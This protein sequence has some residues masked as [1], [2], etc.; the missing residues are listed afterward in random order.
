MSGTIQQHQDYLQANT[1]LTNLL[2]MKGCRNLYSTLAER[3]AAIPTKTSHLV[4]CNSEQGLQTLLNEEFNQ[5][6]GMVKTEELA[7]GII[8]KFLRVSSQDIRENRILADTDLSRNVAEIQKIKGFMEGH[9][10]STS[11]CLL[12]M[13]GKTSYWASYFPDVNH[14]YFKQAFE[15]YKKEQEAREAARVLASAA[16]MP[17]T[18]EGSPVATKSQDTTTAAPTSDSAALMPATSEGSPVTTKSQDITTAA[19]TSE[20]S[21]VATTSADTPTV[22]P[23]LESAATTQQAQHADNQEAA[24]TFRLAGFDSEVN[25]QPLLSAEEPQ[26]LHGSEPSSSSSC[27]SFPTA[28][29]TSSVE[30]FEDDP[31][32]QEPAV[33]TSAPELTTPKTKKPIAKSASATSFK[34]VVVK[35]EQPEVATKS[36]QPIQ[37]ANVPSPKLPAPPENQTGTRRGSTDTKEASGEKKKGGTT[38]HRRNPAPTKAGTT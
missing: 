21:S 29:L 17:A 26:S 1:M 15:K 8:A 35:G 12:R 22:A 31:S 6:D 36:S 38:V 37:A 28:S 18:S 10:N 13:Q 5:Y 11:F 2:H 7:L 34:A 19:P 32:D 20:G 24:V 16:L 30:S 23:T 3:V 33:T 14:I 9:L 25:L 27:P 4:G